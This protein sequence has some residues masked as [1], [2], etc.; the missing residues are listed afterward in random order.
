MRQTI[1]GPS[2]QFGTTVAHRIKRTGRKRILSRLDLMLI[3]GVSIKYRRFKTAVVI[4]KVPKSRFY[5]PLV[6]TLLDESKNKRRFN[7]I[8]K[9][10]S[11]RD[12]PF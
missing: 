9:L 10:S 1:I 12:M 2:D 6:L 3:Q 7:P 8:E 11:R 4:A 5:V